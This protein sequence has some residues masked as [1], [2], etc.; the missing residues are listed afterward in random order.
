MIWQRGQICESRGLCYPVISTAG[1]ASSE[2]S[3][4]Q[5]LRCLQEGSLYW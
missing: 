2:G 4:C 3:S 5:S 1:V